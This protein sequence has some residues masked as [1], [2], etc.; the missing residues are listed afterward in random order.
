MAESIVALPSGFVHRQAAHCE[1]GAA[2]ALLR[3]AGLDI[4][5]ALAFGVGA[6]LF[7]GYVPFIKLNGFPL[8]TYRSRPGA[9]LAR[10]DK[11]LGCA[12]RCK[13]YRDR[14][15]AMDELDD[16]LEQ[17]RVVG[18][19]TSVFWLP[20]IPAALR[21]HF[22]AHNLLVIARD[23]DDYIVSD[24]VMAEVVRCPADDLCRARFAAGTLAPRGRC[25]YFSAVP[26]AA[27]L[28]AVVASAIRAVCR[29]MLAPVP[30]AGV[31]G[32]RMLARD[33]GRWENKYG[34]RK[35][36]S[37]LA[38]LVRMQEEIGT[39]G[40]GF[41]FIYAAFLQEAATLL[42]RPALQEHASALTAIGDGWR[43][44]AVQATRRCKGQEDAASV[45]ELAAM[46]EQQ[47]QREEQFFR[48]LVAT[49]KS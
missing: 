20:Y 49:V 17:G 15:R 27:R 19:Q 39:G 33:M 12:M 37:A 11:T 36:L 47:A 1:S 34:R 45:A 21:F 9:I 3:Q 16:M 4:S 14:Q 6:G 7:F 44:F 30:I 5:E 46:V 10:L 26:S 22:N 2:A 42:Q 18:L 48:A 38:Q 13:R 32:M 40:A 35:A 29:D 8:V 23:G 25:Y 24:P 41:R 43:E 31:R 28:P